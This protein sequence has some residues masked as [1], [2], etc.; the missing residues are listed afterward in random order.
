M[1]HELWRYVVVFH[2]VVCFT[3]GEIYIIFSPVIVTGNLWYKCSWKCFATAISKSLPNAKITMVT[4]DHCWKLLRIIIFT[5]ITWLLH[6]QNVHHVGTYYLLVFA[7]MRITTH[8]LEKH[9]SL[10]YTNEFVC[11]QLSPSL[12]KKSTYTL[13]TSKFGSKN[14]FSSVAHNRYYCNWFVAKRVVR[15]TPEEG[16]ALM[17]NLF[18]IHGLINSWTCSRSTCVKFQT[19]RSSRNRTPQFPQTFH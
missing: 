15:I 9:I 6:K 14:F 12:W 19:L 4:V 17:S 10:F 3:N 7:T 13:W 1:C 2:T 11:I 8:I 18:S 16:W 5:N